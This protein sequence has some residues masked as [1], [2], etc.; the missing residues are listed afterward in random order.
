MNHQF[1]EYTP[2]ELVKRGKAFETAARAF[3]KERPKASTTEWTEFN[4][5][6]FARTVAKVC[7]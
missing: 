4:L 6:W 2:E 5:D 7:G 3:A 1:H